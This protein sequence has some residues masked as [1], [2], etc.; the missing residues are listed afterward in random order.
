[1]RGGDRRR[2]GRAGHDATRPAWFATAPPNTSPHT[3]RRTYIS[4]AR[5]AN[6]FDVLWVMSQVGHA[7]SEMTMDVDAQLQL[8]VD[9]EHGRA[10]DALF[11]QARGRLCERGRPV[12]ARQRHRAS[13]VDKHPLRRAIRAVAG[14]IAPFAAWLAGRGCPAAPSSS[15]IT[16]RRRVSPRRFAVRRRPGAAFASLTR[17]L[18]SHAPARQS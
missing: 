3:L 17:G 16:R 1:M 13:S 6:R 18:V 9:R 2:S 4:I 10:F 15:T 14:R 7:D 8:R 11:R 5:L 12:F